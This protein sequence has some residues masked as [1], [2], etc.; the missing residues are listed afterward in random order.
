MLLALIP[1]VLILAVLYEFSSRRSVW[2]RRTVQGMMVISVFAA[3][4]SALKQVRFLYLDHGSVLEELLSSPEPASERTEINWRGQPDTLHTGLRFLFDPDH[5]RLVSYLLGHTSTNETI[6]LGLSRHDRILY[7]DLLTYF[8]AGRLPATRWS[9]FDPD[10]QTRAD[11]QRQMIQEIDAQAVR[12]IVLE[13]EFDQ[14]ME[15][16]ND[17]SKSS[18]VRLLDDYIRSNYHPIQKFG[19]L[20]LLLRNGASA[21]A[22]QSGRAD[23]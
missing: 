2:L 12:F 7:N 4:W 8:V 18:G 16:S 21:D 9:H 15:L 13:F 3:T 17:S 11:I 10:L 20:C 6:F 1:M 14:A 22:P 19:A 23:Q 5:S